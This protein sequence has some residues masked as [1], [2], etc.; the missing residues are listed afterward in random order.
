[1]TRSR[2]EAIQHYVNVKNKM[3]IKSAYDSVMCRSNLM[4]FGL[5]TLR[6]Q[7]WDIQ[8]VEIQPV[9]MRDMC[10]G[11]QVVVVV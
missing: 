8:K 1:L 2:S 4:Y 3:R 7:H 11:L 5:P 10:N 6:T 9:K